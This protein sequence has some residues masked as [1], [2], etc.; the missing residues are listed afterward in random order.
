MKLISH[1]METKV[2]RSIKDPELGPLPAE[3]Q[4]M[5]P[6]PRSSFGSIRCSQSRDLMIFWCPLLK[7]K[8]CISSLEINLMY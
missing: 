3:L 8:G 7:V 6:N 4:N 5:T 1:S 2:Y